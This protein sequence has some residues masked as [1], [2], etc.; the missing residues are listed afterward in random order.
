MFDLLLSP[1]LNN[2]IRFRAARR[3]VG[4]CMAGDERMVHE[5]FA[6][7]LMSAPQLSLIT[8]RIEISSVTHILL[9]FMIGCLGP[10]SVRERSTVLMQHR[11]FEIASLLLPVSQSMLPFPALVEYMPLLQLYN[12]RMHPMERL[13]EVVFA[14]LFLIQL[15]DSESISRTADP[16]IVAWKLTQLFKVFLLSSDCFFDQRINDLLRSLLRNLLE[17][18]PWPQFD[19]LN[20]VSFRDFFPDVVEQFASVSFG[21]GTFASFIALLLHQCYDVTYRALIWRELSGQLHLVSP[22]LNDLQPCLTPNELNGDLLMRYVQGLVDGEVTATRAPFMFAIAR[23]HVSCALQNDM[24]PVWQRRELRAALSV[25]PLILD[26][27]SSSFI[28]E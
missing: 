3:C 10:D 24:V 20:D 15:Y 16:V 18:C 26:M 4:H 27:V 5:L 12:R 23:H 21:D 25:K 1:Q 28:P 9:D 14:T 6:R 8:Q 11:S 22:A 13:N 7:V 17:V 19:S 2:I